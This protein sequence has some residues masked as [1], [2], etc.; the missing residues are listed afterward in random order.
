MTKE[1]KIQMYRKN[2]E[3]QI[4][5]RKSKII[6]L[7]IVPVIGAALTLLIGTI[8]NNRQNEIASATVLENRSVGDFLG[9]NDSASAIYTGTVKAVDPV[10]IIEEHG[11]YISLHRKV[12]REEKIYDKDSDKYDTKTKVIS[13]DN[14][15]CSEIEMD[16]V[17]IPYSFFH[18]LPSFSDTRSEGAASNLTKTTFTYTP[19]EIE[20]TFFLQCEKGKVTSAQ[21]YGS[22]D[23]AGESKR[24]FVI[25]K[26]IIWIIIIGIVIYLI[27]GIMRASEAIKNIEEKCNES[28]G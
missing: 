7:I 22:E 28:G 5:S 4:K 27:L 9:Q 14:D 3:K 6:A 17:V 23:V 26:V 21:Y 25:A 13:D 2:Q 18:N 24:G 16:D 10:S 12:E 1:D 8:G 11:E 19:S 20:G 15:H